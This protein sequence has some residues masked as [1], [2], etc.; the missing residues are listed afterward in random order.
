MEHLFEHF[1]R[2]EKVDP[3]SIGDVGHVEELFSS[4]F[5]LMKKSGDV[6]NIIK[7]EPP[8]WWIFFF[9]VIIIHWN[10]S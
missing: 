4:N 8:L 6:N 2:D 5:M 1:L 10:M 9:W 7:F 3:P